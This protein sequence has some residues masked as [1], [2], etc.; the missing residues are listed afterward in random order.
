MNDSKLKTQ[1]DYLRAM[2]E[3]AGGDVIVYPNMYGDFTMQRY[4]TSL[5]IRVS[6]ADRREVFDE[7]VRR[8]M[9]AEPR[10]AERRTHEHH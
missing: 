7:K 8:L 10:T 1:A 6:L 3:K 4:G 9:A 2:A 5:T